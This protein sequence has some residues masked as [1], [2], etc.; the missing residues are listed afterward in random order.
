MNAG[1]GQPLIRRGV[2]V[3]Y[4]PEYRERT[5]DESLLSTLAGLTPTG[6]EPGALIQDQTGTGDLD[7]LLATNTF[8]HTLEQATSSQDAWHLILLLGSC[9]FFF[10]VFIRRVSVSFAWV[11]P[12][13]IRVR[14]RVLGRDAGV[15]DEEYMNRLRKRKADV[16]E[17]IETRQA[18]TRFEV[19]AAAPVDES[20]VQREI[21]ES[22]VA[23]AATPKQESLAPEKDTDEESYTSRL[24]RAKKDVWRNR[25]D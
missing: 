4:S 19:D 12:L 21:D 17:A 2:N 25:D 16:A 5:T 1:P 11:G 8:R 7:I 9:L 10:D 18:G 6:G 14:E 23:D 15:A 24:L 13:T 3:P 22:T 20:A